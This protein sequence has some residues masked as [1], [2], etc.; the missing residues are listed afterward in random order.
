[1]KKINNN[2]RRNT[3]L[4]AVQ[5][6][7]FTAEKFKE[8]H[9]RIET[10]IQNVNP[11]EEYRDFTEKHKSVTFL[12]ISDN[13]KK[14][15]SLFPFQIQNLTSDTNSISIRSNITRRQRYVR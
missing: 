1:M 10:N 6:G 7:D 12:L 2:F 13:N 14:K 9:R 8:I 11:A 4:D 15:M 5:H 3:L